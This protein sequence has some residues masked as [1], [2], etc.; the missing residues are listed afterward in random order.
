MP[1]GTAGFDQCYDITH[2]LSGSG[3]PVYRRF[4]FFS[5]IP[6][7]YKIGPNGTI[8]TYFPDY[9]KYGGYPY[10]LGG[11]YMSIYPNHPKSGK[12]SGHPKSGKDSGHPKGG[13]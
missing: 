6:G 8:R 13:K 9:V 11:R 2:K 1:F 4:A 7:G 10:P 3:I 5:M 12:D